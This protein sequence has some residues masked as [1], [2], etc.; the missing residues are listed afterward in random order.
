M[1]KLRLLKL[2]HVQLTGRYK[3]FPNSLIWLS[4]HGFPLNYIP[5]EFPMENL[6]TLD[7][8]HSRFGKVWKDTPI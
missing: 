4:W 1:T 2:D 8:H 3:I 5:V 7:L 6:V